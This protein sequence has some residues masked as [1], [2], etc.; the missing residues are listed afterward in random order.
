VTT[1]TCSSYILAKAKRRDYAF[2]YSDL[3]TED[4]TYETL[5]NTIYKLRKE[6]KI[7][8]IP[9]ENPTRFILREWVHRPEYSC[10]QKSDSKSMGVRFDFLSLLES[11]KWEPV[12]AIHALKLKF[13]VYS[14]GWLGTGWEYNTRNHSYRSHFSLSYPVSV[15]CFDTGTVLVSVK[16]SV[17]PF[18]LDL[19][20]ILS[21]ACLLGELRACMRAPCIPEPPNWMI[22]QW[23]LNRD[24]KKMS[25]DGLSFHVS[26]RDFFDNVARLY[27]K[28]ELNKI[29][30]EA[31]QNP[32]RTV[33]EVFESI[34]NREELPNG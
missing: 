15:Q 7:L 21:L 8:K 33:E 9:R 24:S 16:S 26:F 28:H 19:N 5:R 30:A 27:F 14:L 25:I 29:R 12:L 3:E 6:G 13:E 34:L 4:F 1:T 2:C 10:V 32:K 11:L 17:R 31:T 23:H 20:G 22:V 18:R